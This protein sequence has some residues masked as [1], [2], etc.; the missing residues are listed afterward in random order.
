MAAAAAM[1]M[2][3]Q[4]QQPGTVS[5]QEAEIQALHNEAGML[6]EDNRQQTHGTSMQERKAEVIQEVLTDM[7]D[8]TTAERDDTNRVVLTALTDLEKRSRDRNFREE[9]RPMR[10]RLCDLH[11]KLVAANGGE[12]TEG[13]EDTSTED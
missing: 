12:G 2:A 6:E 8:D 10:K 11:D 3:L 5:R 7:D 13:G 4:N 1:A 9:F